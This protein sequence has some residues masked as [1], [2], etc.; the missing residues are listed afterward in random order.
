MWTKKKSRFFNTLETGWCSRNL[1]KDRAKTL[2]ALVPF[3]FQFY[4][5]E[6]LT[7]KM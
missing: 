3:M 7:V 1:K 4:F 6:D 2:G 5:P